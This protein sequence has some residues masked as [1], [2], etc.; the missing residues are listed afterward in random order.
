M[1]LVQH[2]GW[3]ILHDGGDEGHMPTLSLQLKQD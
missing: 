1:Q 3:N 2:L